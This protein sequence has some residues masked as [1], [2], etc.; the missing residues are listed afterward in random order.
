MSSFDNYKKVM[1]IYNNCYVKVVGRFGP[2]RMSG[3]DEPMISFNLKGRCA[4]KCCRRMEAGKINFTIKL[5]QYILETQR[6]AFLA[7]T[8]PHEFA[9]MFVKHLYPLATAHGREWK[10]M[11][12]LLDCDGS[13][14]HSYK[15]V[16]ARK[17]RRVTYVC[18]CMDHEITINMRNKIE[19]GI[20]YHCRICKTSIRKN[21]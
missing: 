4:G 18:D 11:M 16:S 14:C 17:V 9:H 13:R 3:L 7:R 2:E 19:R 6:E 8:V 10:L 15:T 12:N 5:N 1:E 21:K 20:G